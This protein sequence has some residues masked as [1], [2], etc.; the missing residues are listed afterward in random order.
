[1]D[2]WQKAKTEKKVLLL[3]DVYICRVGRAIRAAAP[4]LM[5][6]KVALG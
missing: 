4:S 5:K 3:E 2:F 1:M 6:E